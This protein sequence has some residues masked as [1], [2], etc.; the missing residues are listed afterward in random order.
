[1]NELARRWQRDLEGRCV[2]SVV[3]ETKLA[4]RWAVC[5]VEWLE[6]FTGERLPF[7]RRNC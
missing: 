7:D 4:G 1:M 5:L 3:V 6:K 2:V